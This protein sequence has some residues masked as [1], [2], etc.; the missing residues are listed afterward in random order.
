MSDFDDDET[1]EEGGTPPAPKAGDANAAG[2]GDSSTAAPRRRPADGDDDWDDQPVARRRRPNDDDWDDDWDDDGRGGRA[3][4]DMTLILAII[5][6]VVVIAIV[7]IVTRPSNKS[8]NNAAPPTA[9]APGQ[10]A[11]TPA[12]TGP[13]C[14]NWPGKVGG[15][16]AVATKSAGIY[17]WSDFHGF[18]IRANETSPTTVKVSAPSDMTVTALGGATASSHTGKLITLTLPAATGTTGP[19]LN[20]DCT[21][22][23]ATFDVAASSGGA[24]PASSIKVGDSATADNNPVVFTRGQP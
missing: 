1:T 19:D 17:I 15:N 22:A 5:G 14:P 20:I 23:T 6:A 11:G 13:L 9:T 8:N 7:V 24:L 21:A 2:G 18:H 3:R 10:T 16:G 12:T 4:P